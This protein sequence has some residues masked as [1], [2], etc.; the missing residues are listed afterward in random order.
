MCVHDTEAHLQFK[1]LVCCQHELV[2]LLSE[3][4]FPS[5]KQTYFLKI[6]TFWQAGQNVFLPLVGP[7]WSQYSLIIYSFCL[8]Q[9]I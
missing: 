7:V 9:Q 8:L 1:L 2:I 5:L 6:L 3:K 4:N